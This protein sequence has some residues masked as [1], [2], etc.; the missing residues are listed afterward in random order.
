[1]SARGNPLLAVLG[2]L[3]AQGLPLGVADYLDALRAVNRGFGLGKEDFVRL[4]ISLF[5]KSEADRE[6]VRVA[7]TQVS[8]TVCAEIAREDSADQAA[9]AERQPQQPIPSSEGS[10]V[11]APPAP[12][13][14]PPS[15]TE[16]ASIEPSTVAVTEV[17]TRAPLAMARRLDQ[18]ASVV[19]GAAGRLPSGDYA[20][21]T[22]RALQQGWRR[23][24]LAA[25]FGPRVELDAVAT[26]EQTARD[27]VL[28]DVILRARRINRSELMILCDVGG[29]MVPFHQL[30]ERLVDTACGGR[31]REV[32]ARYFHDSVD[33]ILDTTPRGDAASESFD[34][35][36]IKLRSRWARVIV[37]SDAGAARGRYDQD[38]V[39]AT[40]EWL[41]KLQ[42]AAPV[43]WLNPMPSTRWLGTTAS[44]IARLVPMY[45]LSAIGF[46][47]AIGVLRH[48][49]RRAG[50]RD[51]ARR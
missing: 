9:R 22:T 25:R 35:A 29:S 42:L 40:A 20:P 43:A 5:A 21:V 10:L 41:D 39:A 11:E 32:R 1:M 24:R 7:A 4:C 2:L 30:G 14:V 44:A 12:A 23:M 48:G 26:I 19:R 46:S 47:R 45:E 18:V 36:L 6:L 27:G 16:R 3:R 15:E 50:E 38:R 28:S 34:R 37:F 51:R 33:E 13:Q 17:V 8:T 31:F 49:E